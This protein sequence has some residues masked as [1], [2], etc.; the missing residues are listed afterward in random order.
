MANKPINEVHPGKVNNLS[1]VAHPGVDNYPTYAVQPVD[2]A[3]P[4]VVN[5][6]ASVAHV[7]HRWNSGAHPRAASMTTASSNAVR[8]K[9]TRSPVLAAQTTAGR[10]D[11]GPPQLST[12]PDDSGGEEESDDSEA[13]FLDDDPDYVPGS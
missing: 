4:G 7:S 5:N 13:S 2:A 12:K 3:N 1:S 9:L 11:G 8:P 10:M 6:A